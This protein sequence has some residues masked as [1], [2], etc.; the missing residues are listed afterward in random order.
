MGDVMSNAPVTKL[1]F[2]VM[3]NRMRYILLRSGHLIECSF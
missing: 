2:K 1:T 3:D